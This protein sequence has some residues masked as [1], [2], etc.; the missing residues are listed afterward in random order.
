[1]QLYHNEIA[2]VDAFD[3]KAFPKALIVSD[4]KL[5]CDTIKDRITEIKGLSDFVLK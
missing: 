3:W 2:G 5:V 1:M 4:E